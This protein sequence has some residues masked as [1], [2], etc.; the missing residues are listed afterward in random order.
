MPRPLPPP[1][2]PAPQKPGWPVLRVPTASSVCSSRQAPL[3]SCRLSFQ[4]TQ[5]RVRLF[6]A[7]IDMRRHLTILERIA[8]LGSQEA[9]RRVARDAGIEAI[10][11]VAHHRGIFVHDVREDLE[12]V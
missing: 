10:D 6:G 4:L 1:L 11:Q 2:F 3:S 8:Q 12:I 9:A 5:M 7:L